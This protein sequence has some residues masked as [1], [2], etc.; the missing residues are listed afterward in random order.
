MKLSK[1]VIGL[2]TV[3][4]VLLIII[5]AMIYKD[6]SRADG[7]AD[8][9]T[10]NTTESTTDKPTDTDTKSELDN[11]TA[12]IELDKE[13]E[14]R[15]ANA[16]SNVELCQINLEF[17]DKWKEEIDTYYQK[18]LSIAGP[19]FQQK[20]IESQTEWYINAE[21][22]IDERFA[23]FKEVYQTGTIVP[24]AQSYFECNLYRER[25]IELFQMYDELNRIKLAMAEYTAED[26]SRT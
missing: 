25:A 16:Q 23:Y 26:D 10:S 2:L 19:D 13:L 18:L 21:K 1:S 5:S 24:I 20:L 22:H 7:G 11:Y 17:K 14:R 15:A 8:K 4:A 12:A 6:F 3:I 9:E